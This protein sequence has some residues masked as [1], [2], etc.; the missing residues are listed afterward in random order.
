[1]DEGPEIRRD[2]GAAGRERPA[3]GRPAPAV[4]ARGALRYARPAMGE[5]VRDD[6]SKRREAV[7]PSS[8]GLV[9][10]YSGE[11]PCFH[12][13]RLRKGRL[14][15]GRDDLA[16]L[17]LADERVS[18]RHLEIEHDGAI[19][20]V[21]D[22]GSTNGT[23]LDGE[24]IDGERSSRA[25]R[26]VRIGR[27][28]LLPIGDSALYAL[29][30]LTEK[31]DRVVGPSLRRVHEQIARIAR[32][33]QGLLLTGGSGSGK[34]VAA[35]VYH[36]AAGGKRADAR[37]FVA[38]NCATVQ[39]ELAERILF[40]ARRGAY[41]GAVADAEGLMQAAHGGTLFLDEIAELEAGVQAKLLRVLETR[42]VTP[43]G[44]LRPEAVDFHLCA[45]THK[46]LRAEVVAGRFREDLYFRIGRPELTLPPLRDR[47][48]EIPWI[49]QRAV[50]SVSS[51]DMRHA[52][53]AEL[54]EACLLRPWP[55]NVR[56]LLAEVR[57]ATLAAG[58]RASILDTD[59]AELAGLELEPAR[60][61]SL[62]PSG[63]DGE[64]DPIEAALAAEGGSATRAAAR[65]GISRGKVRRF[66]EKQGLDRKK[67]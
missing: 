43:L 61:A 38:L 16:A 32:A 62:P 10:A 7:D 1:V 22:C 36:E 29:H 24:P 3:P 18:H 59:L 41:S 46:D 14:A 40:G 50:E 4:V 56:E 49:V 65:L 39:R 34:E 45:A 51:A 8:P 52:A 12:V 27:T 60:R 57:A 11:A 2:H 58:D 53:S 42:E 64:L 30:G 5:T 66:M 48:E 44:G 47:P 23:F 67:G 17:R 13:L 54:V 63:D 35:R 37:P 33:G 26:V 6:R 15:L 28:L 21:R 25:P 19:W 31:G 20:T 9:V 55:G